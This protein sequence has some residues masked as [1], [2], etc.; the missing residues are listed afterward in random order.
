[1]HRWLEESMN[2]Y[3]PNFNHVM[4]AVRLARKDAKIGKP[5]SAEI[6]KRKEKIFSHEN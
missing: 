2:N 4:K 6:L 1:M 5:I 3:S